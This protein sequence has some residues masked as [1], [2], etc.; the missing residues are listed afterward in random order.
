VMLPACR[1]VRGSCVITH[2]A[3]LSCLLA[4]FPLFYC[5]HIHSFYR[6]PPCLYAHSR[7]AHAG[8]ERLIITRFPGG[9][10]VGTRWEYA[11]WWSE[12]PTC[13]RAAHSFGGV[14]SPAAS[15]RSPAMRRCRPARAAP[16][17]RD[18]APVSGPREPLTPRQDGGGAPSPLCHQL[19]GL[20]SFIIR[21]TAP[22]NAVPRHPSWKGR[23]RASAKAS[24]S[25]LG[26]VAGEAKYPCLAHAWVSH[27]ILQ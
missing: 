10:S 11:W 7:R 20:A 24:S 17:R 22:A 2:A 16:G 12:P 4:S 14:D 18:E 9:G 26:R 5:I 8:L 6:M 25:S 27:T 23:I 13:G 21:M 1:G 15:G 19:H 3:L